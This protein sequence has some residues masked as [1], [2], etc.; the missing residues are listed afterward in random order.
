M[1]G[2][3]QNNLFLLLSLIEAV[4]H[5]LLKYPLIFTLDSAAI[6]SLLLGHCGAFDASQCVVHASS[7][8]C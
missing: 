6:N 7:Y 8:V 3:K 2:K 4:C 1:D 5:K